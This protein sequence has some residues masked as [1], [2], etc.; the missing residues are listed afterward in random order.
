[1]K[2]V[3]IILAIHNEDYN[4]PIVLKS[5]EKVKKDLQYD[6]EVIAVNDGSTDNSLYQINKALKKYDFLKII[7]HPYKMGLTTVVES[8][9]RIASGDIIMFFPCDME[10][11]P[12]EDI[13][14]LLKPIEEGYDVAAGMRIGRADGKLITSRMGNFLISKIFGL[15]LHDINWV[16]A[17]TREAVDTMVLKYY[18]VRYM[19]LFPHF[20]GMKI[21]EVETNWYPRTYGHSKYGPLRL[22]GALKDLVILGYCYYTGHFKRRCLDE[23]NSKGII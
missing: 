8:A 21:A 17:M 11:H 14:K 15:N 23:H 2:C 10:S 16:K 9:I 20:H 7:N 6:M 13:P 22:I 12:N 1:M 4:I 18:W 3:S 19:L 5:L